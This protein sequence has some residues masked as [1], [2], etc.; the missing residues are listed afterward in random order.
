MRT[1]FGTGRGGGNHRSSV[2]RLH[3]GR[4]MIEA[5]FSKDVP[6]WGS[7]ESPKASNLRKLEEGLE[8]KISDYIGRLSVA[9]IEVPGEVIEGQ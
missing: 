4:S 6:S 3:I 5:G 8:A 7:V 2:F 1:H 9:F